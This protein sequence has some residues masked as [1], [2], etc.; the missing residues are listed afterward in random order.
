MCSAVSQHNRGDEPFGPKNYLMITRM[1]MNVRG[2]IIFDY[3]D[4]FQEARQKLIKWLSSGQIKNKE[5]T[6]NDGLQQAEH[7]LVGLHNGI[8]TGKLF[9][10]VAKADA[11]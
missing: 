11:Y 1:R 10:E 3:A 9:V 8:N 7:G 2:F 6:L 4:R 5:T